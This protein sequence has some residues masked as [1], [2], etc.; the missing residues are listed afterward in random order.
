MDI[1]ELERMI[2]AER[3]AA[4]IVNTISR[5]GERLFF[6]AMDALQAREMMI[7]ADP[8]RDPARLRP[9]VREAVERGYRLIIVGG[10]DGTISAVVDEFAY[11]DAVLGLLPLGTGN[12]FARTLN[13][14]LTLNGAI[15]VIT[16]GRVA[17]VDLG[18]VGDDYFANIAAIGLSAEMA[19]TT[20]ARL[21]HYVGQLAYVLVG[22]RILLRHQPFLC[23]VRI[24]DSQR[25]YR[26]HEVVIA[27]GRVFG[28]TV[29]TEDASITSGKLVIATMETLNRRQLLARWLAFLLGRQT[30][31]RG[32][33][34]FTAED[35][36]IDTTPPQAIDI[37][38]EVTAHTPAHFT[39][40][41]RALKVLVPR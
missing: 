35:V 23:T 16:T 40:A 29:L 25:S 15:E 18:R 3:T 32:V 28:D 5:R 1:D 22:A 39:V 8:V 14:P 30:A 6:Q 13:V 7:A 38:G 31:F 12:S 17:A 20:P 10:G 33:Y 37:D 4:L 41:P 19:R 2:H 24:A 34:H 27:N 11:R 26:T 9:A 36:W 21:K